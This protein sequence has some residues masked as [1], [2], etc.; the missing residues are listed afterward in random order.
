MLEL[1]TFSGLSLAQEGRRLPEAT[2]HRKGLALLA[3]LAASH[4]RGVEREYLLSLLWP[5]SDETHARGALKQSLYSLRRLV[6]TS[7]LV[8]GRSQLFLNSAEITSDVGRF[9]AALAAG[10]LEQAVD[11]YTGP[12]L[13]GVHLRGA[14]E[15]EDWMDR[16]RETLGDSYRAALERLARRSDAMGDPLGAVE[17]WRR[18]V[19]EDPLNTRVTMGLI[20][21][22]DAAGD[23]AGALRQISLHRMH[24]QRELGIEPNREFAAFTARLGQ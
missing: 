21:A 6:G 14:R 12:F 7:A 17:W 5:E 19:A 24:L 13:E 18:L 15:F 23:R 3:V 4:P 10:D 1:V 2:E 16:A 11:E 9:R 20:T 22:L 8:S